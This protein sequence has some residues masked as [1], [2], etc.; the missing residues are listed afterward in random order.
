MIHLHNNLLQVT[1]LVREEPRIQDSCPSLSVLIVTRHSSLSQG[2]Y[3][4]IM[5]LNISCIE[6]DGH[7]EPRR[8][9]EE[10]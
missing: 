4:L 6:I 10:H 8:L 3:S 2:S 9:T 1:Q 7:L 5:L